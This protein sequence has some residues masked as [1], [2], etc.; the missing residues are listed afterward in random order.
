MSKSVP[1]E[2][3]HAYF[4]YVED[5]TDHGGFLEIPSAREFCNMYLGE[6]NEFI[7]LRN[8]DGIPNPKEPLTPTNPFG[9]IS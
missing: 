2:V 9:L 6:L 3:I 7:A 5:I 4:D 1:I 8:T